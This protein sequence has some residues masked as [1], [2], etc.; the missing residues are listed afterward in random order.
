MGK[1]N[2]TKEH[3]D[4]MCALLMRMLLNN[5]V[6]PTAIGTPLDAV[7]LLH[8]TTINTLNTI[9]HSLTKQIAKLEDADEWIQTEVVQDKLDSLKD[10]KELVNLIIGYKRFLTEQAEIKQ[11]KAI[12]TAKIAEMKEAIKSP[13]EKLKE[14]EAELSELKEE[15]L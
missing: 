3:Y 5:W 11:K 1:I 8:T 7:A 10:S 12:L 9:R 6:I 2:F 14:A 13:E 15:Q 4:K